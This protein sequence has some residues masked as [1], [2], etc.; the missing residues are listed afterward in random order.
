MAENSG[1]AASRNAGAGN[2]TGEVLVFIDSDVLVFPESMR[3]VSEY[4]EENNNFHVLQ[5]VYTMEGEQSNLPTLAREYFKFHKM[6]K[7]R[8]NEIS[9]INSFCFA[10]RKEVFDKAGGFNEKIKT[11]A[12]EDTDFAMR[13][14][15]KGYK[16]LLEKKMKVSHLKRYSFSGLLG[17]DFYKSKA[18]MKLILRRGN[19]GKAPVTISLNRLGDVMPEIISVFVSPFFF[20]TFILSFFYGKLP[21]VISFSAAALFALLNRGYFRI[22]LENKNFNTACGCLLVFLFESLFYFFGAASALFDYYVL[23]KKY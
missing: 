12:S 22:I 1:P 23:R 14:A 21:A 15:G 6:S 7:L 20:L 13:L 3:F 2:S 19:K 4:F 17:S 9:G 5:G 18:K 10:I 16:I 8:H 11:A